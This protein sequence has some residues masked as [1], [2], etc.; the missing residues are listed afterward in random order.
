M[1]EWIWYAVLAATLVAL[2]YLIW[3]EVWI[4]IVRARA[5]QEEDDNGYF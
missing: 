1:Y 5:L 2:L 4:A 3:K